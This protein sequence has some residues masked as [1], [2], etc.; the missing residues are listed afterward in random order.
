MKPI[1]MCLLLLVALATPA[2]AAPKKTNPEVA[3]NFTFTAGFGDTNDRFSTGN[4]DHVSIAMAA[5]VSAN[6]TLLA[7]WRHD[8]TR[9]DP[10]PCA[11]GGWVP[12][13]S[14][15]WVP[16]PRHVDGNS[17]TAGIRLYLR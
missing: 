5:P 14:I 15:Y 8:H 6:V 17:F 4:T 2:W 16:Y 10:E 13:K 11:W 1:L 12:L 7:S 3:T 9:W